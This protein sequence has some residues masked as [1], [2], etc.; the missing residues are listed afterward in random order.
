MRERSSP[1]EGAAASH[2][3]KKVLVADDEGVVVDLLDYFLR[4]EGH[5][6]DISRDGRAALNK[7]KE[8][9]YDLILC[10]IKMPEVSGQNLFHWIETTK[11]HLADRVIF[12]TGDVA[13]PETLPFLNHP[14]KRWLEKPF[15]LTELHEL[16]AEVLQ[17]EETPRAGSP[18]TGC[19]SKDCAG[20]VPIRQSFIFQRRKET[21]AVKDREHLDQSL[22]QAVNDAIVAPDDLPN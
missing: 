16:I 17:R 7:L 10:D 12:I 6:V 5:A 20:E 22:S 1:P 2:A 3:T 19:R 15:D 21:R 9:D 18:E 13:T 14:P 11:P 4:S 8:S